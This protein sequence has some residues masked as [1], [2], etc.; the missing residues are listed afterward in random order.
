MAN[1][2]AARKDVSW[3]ELTVSSLVATM[4]LCLAASWACVT[5]GRTDDMSAARSDLHLAAK[6]AKLTVVSKAALMA[7]WSAHT[8]A[9]AKAAWLGCSWV[10]KTATWLAV[11]T[12]WCSVAT[13][14]ATTARR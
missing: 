12:A 2:S 13:L 11:S 7:E 9:G 3:V 8:M 6:R 1:Y 14:A 5:A 4:V 10:V